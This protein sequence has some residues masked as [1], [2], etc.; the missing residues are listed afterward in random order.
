[1][2][3]WKICVVPNMIANYEPCEY[4]IEGYSWN[5][6][7]VALNFDKNANFV[8]ITCVYTSVRWLGHG[9]I[10]ILTFRY[11]K[12][13]IKAKFH[14]ELNNLEEYTQFQVRL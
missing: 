10:L 13:F 11:E 7:K 6:V 12:N 8:S 1:M 4:C 3:F 14:H 2:V 9:R 5:S